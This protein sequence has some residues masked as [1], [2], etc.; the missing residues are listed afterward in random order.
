LNEPAAPTPTERCGQQIHG[1]EAIPVLVVDA[2]YFRCLNHLLDWTSKQAFRFDPDTMLLG[3]RARQI[4]HYE[5]G[6]T[7]MLL[8]VTEID[9]AARGFR[10]AGFTVPDLLEVKTFVPFATM[11]TLLSQSAIV[12]VDRYVPHLA[13]V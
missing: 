1:K 13:V 7:P 12:R 11:Q 5:N 6:H 10:L 8:A 2:A 3:L 4:V 9:L